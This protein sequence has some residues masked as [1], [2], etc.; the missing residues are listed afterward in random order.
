MKFI[1]YPYKMASNSAR[2]LA[3]ALNTKRVLPDG[4]YFPKRSHVII[5]WGNHKWPNWFTDEDGQAVHSM[6]NECDAVDVA[7][8]K[9]LTFLSLKDEGVSI[10][11]FTT[12]RSVANDWL[13]NAGPVLERHSLTGSRG[14]GIVYRESGTVNEAPLYVRYVPKKA[15][16]RVHVFKEEVIDVQQKRKSK[17]YEG[18][19]DTKIRNHGNG[20]VFCRDNVSP[21]P[22]VTSS[23]V[24]A[25]KA[26]GLDFGAADV[27]WNEKQQKAYVLEVNTAPGLEGTTLEKYVNAFK[28]L[29]LF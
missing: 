15:E 6:L 2:E 25:I 17:S 8:N 18:T 28:G 21:N 26:L 7:R 5:N 10:P 23:A 20:W 19:V 13:R 3:K 22:A 14:S 11:Q 4:N 16:Y 1:I 12:E 29:E 9:L 27:I 24:A